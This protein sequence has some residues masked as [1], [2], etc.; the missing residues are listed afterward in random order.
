M[1]RTPIPDPQL[2]HCMHRDG[3]HLTAPREATMTPMKCPLTAAQVH[4]QQLLSQELIDE[5][6]KETTP[7]RTEPT[8]GSED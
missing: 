6:T 4:N 1:S 2:E 3:M 5:T 7:K 8:E